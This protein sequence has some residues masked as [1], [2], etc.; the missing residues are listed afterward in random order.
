[1]ARTAAGASIRRL[2]RPL[3]LIVAATLA[4]LAFP[5]AAQAVFK[6]FRTPSGKI[7]CAYHDGFDDVLQIRCDLL[8]RNDRA[9][10]LRPSGRGRI[11]KVTDAAGNPKSRVLAYG[12]STRFGVYTCI[13]RRTG[14]TCRSRR[15][16]HGFTVSR[17]SQ[18]V[19]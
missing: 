1:L 4:A 9:A 10:V 19:F 12:T 6:T 15:T 2:R 3:P 5:A 16:G 11:V 7:L 8:F 13:S 14:L 18:K 17:E